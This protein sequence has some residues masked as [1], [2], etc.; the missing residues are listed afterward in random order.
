MPR[1]STTGTYTAPASTVRNAVPNTPIVAADFNGLVDDL[2]AALTDSLSRSGKGG[3]QTPFNYADGS[4]GA[5]SITFTNDADTGFFLSAVGKLGVTVAGT[6]RA[7]WEAALATFQTAV[8]VEGDLTVTGAATV[9]GRL[10]A[11]G[12]IAQ[13]LVISPTSGADTGTSNL[14]DVDAP[15]LTAAN[16][17]CTGGRV[18]IELVSENNGAV[19]QSYIYLSDVT[20]AYPYAAIDIWRSAHSAGTWTKVAAFRFKQGTSSVL[21]THELLPGGVSYLDNPGAGAWD[22]KLMYRVGAVTTTVAIVAC[23]L[24]AYEL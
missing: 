9:T 13:A 4:A 1:N 3:M 22:Y 8:R 21:N 15:N 7:F 23:Q 17:V 18:K 20:A 16:L 19:F 2:E 10:T 5:P 14:V 24:I 12:G 11:T 6:M